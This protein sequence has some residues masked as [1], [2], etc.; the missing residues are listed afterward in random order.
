MGNLKTNIDEKNFMGMKQKEQNYII[1][2]AVIGNDK[3]ITALEKK[4]WIRNMMAFGGGMLG[5][6]LAKIGLG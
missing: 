4:S 2:K 1:Y 6:G 5:G 3:R